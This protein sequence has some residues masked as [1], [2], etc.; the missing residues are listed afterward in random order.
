MNSSGDWRTSETI[1]RSMSECILRY[2]MNSFHWLTSAL[3]VI[4]RCTMYS[5]CEILQSAREG[6]E[7]SAEQSSADTALCDRVA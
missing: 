4:A 5:I 2:Y 3:L 6:G 1:G 7:V